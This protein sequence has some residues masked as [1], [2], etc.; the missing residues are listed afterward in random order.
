MNTAAPPSAIVLEGEPMAIEAATFQFRTSE[1][2]RRFAHNVDSALSSLMRD[3]MRS[4]APGLTQIS[5][6][7]Y[8]D[9]TLTFTTATAVTIP[10]A[11]TDASVEAVMD[12]IVIQ[13]DTD[14]VV[15]VAY[16]VAGA[17]RQLVP[18]IEAF[19]HRWPATSAGI[20]RGESGDL[21]GGI[22]DG[23]PRLQDLPVGWSMEASARLHVASCHG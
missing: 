2:A 23:T 11:S 1:D 8:G 13:K 5:F 9:L 6:P 19:D 15:L 22:T 4:N 14:V 17:V 21:E 12:A 7:T 20:M 16:S 3:T 10:T 18:I